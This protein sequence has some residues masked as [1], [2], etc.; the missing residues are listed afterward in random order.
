MLTRENE[1]SKD[2]LI[3]EF[4]SNIATLKDEL[5]RSKSGESVEIL[6]HKINTNVGE[7]FQLVGIQKKETNIKTTQAMLKDDF[8]RLKEDY[9]TGM[10]A[11]LN[12]LQSVLAESNSIT[13][14]RGNSPTH[15]LSASSDNESLFIPKQKKRTNP[16]N[17][18]SSIESDEE[19]T[20]KT[21]YQQKERQCEKLHKCL[22]EKEK[23]LIRK[24]NVHALEI[25][26]LVQS[27]TRKHLNNRH[28]L[29]P[30]T[31]LGKVANRM[32]QTEFLQQ[33]LLQLKIKR[34]EVEKE[35]QSAPEP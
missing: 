21:K 8:V 22:E 33:C 29:K 5:T 11:V 18:S 6:Q 14:L 25:D 26:T 17:D 4:E 32:G 9:K 3:K 1:E 10:I 19:M 34:T 2:R 31:N 27:L 12:Q 13:P 30:S 28:R 16:L 35:I 15:T 24:D 20:W 23:C 7:N